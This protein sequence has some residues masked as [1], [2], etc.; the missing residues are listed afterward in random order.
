MAVSRLM[1]VYSIV[2]YLA[3]PIIGGPFQFK[4]GARLVVET[5]DLLHRL[6]S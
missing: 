3:R 1:S 2:L 4:I 5:H 6:H